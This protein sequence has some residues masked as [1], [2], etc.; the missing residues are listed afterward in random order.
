MKEFLWV[1]T[2]HKNKEDATKMANILLEEGLIACANIF[3][4][5]T[6]IYKWEGE[7]VNDTETIMIL[8]T[9]QMTPWKK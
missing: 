7:I 6:S 5:A 9:T 1:Y 3:D 2:T 8:K 4:N